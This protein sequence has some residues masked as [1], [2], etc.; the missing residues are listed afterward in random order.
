MLIAYYT[1]FNECVSTNRKLLSIL[2]VFLYIIYS[3]ADYIW[4]M[5]N[6][7]W[8][9]H[10]SDSSAYYT[11]IVGKSFG[12]VLNIEGTNSFYF[13]VNWLTY[14][15][16]SDPFFCS[17]VLRLDN[18]LVYAVAY[19]LVSNK[20][21]DIGIFDFI[22]LFNPYI[23]ITV[24]RNVRD[25]YIILFVVIIISALGLIP[26][27]RLKK[28]WL[29]VGCFLLYITRPILLALI[30]CVIFFKK[31]EIMPKKLRYTV[32]IL[33]VIGTLSLFPYIFITVFN[34]MVSAI[35]YIGEDTEE[36][37]QLLSGQISLPI[38]ISLIKRLSIGLISMMFTPHPINYYIY[39]HSESVVNGVTG[40]YTYL[41]N[42]MILIGGVFNYI[43]IIPVIVSTLKKNISNKYLMFFAISFIVLYVVAYVGVVDIRNRNTAVFFLILSLLYNQKDIKISFYDYLLTTCIFCGIYLISH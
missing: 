38:V 40:I 33:L 28:I 41:D 29:F 13:I 5:D 31:K 37:V 19:L 12:Q 11:E 20:C 30:M 42:I 36:Y 39:I 35:N 7:S 25:C 24:V 9:F 14:S 8:P 21:R 27:I 32:Y 17:A 34:Q 10:P 16:W 1:L 18:I 15:F 2:S 22:L 26:N 3:I 43:L 6:L 4:L 23:F